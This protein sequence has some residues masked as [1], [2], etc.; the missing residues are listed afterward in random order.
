VLASAGD[1]GQYTSLTIGSSGLGLMSYY[2]ASVQDLK[3]AYCVDIACTA[4]TLVTLDSAGTVGSYT[5]LTIGTDG[6]PLISYYDTTNGDLK[7]AHCESEFCTPFFR[8][9]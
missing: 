3:I 6:F 1:V 8:R 2:D 5:A 9:R 4:V 7:V